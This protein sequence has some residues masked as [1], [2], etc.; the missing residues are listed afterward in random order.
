M[1]SIVIFK[2][3]RNPQDARVGADGSV[4]WRG[5]KME[6]NDDDPAAMEIASSIADGGEIIG[7]T[8]GDGD[9]SWAASRGA[10]RTVIVTDAQ[11]E[12]DSSMTGAVLASAIRQIEDVD[13]VFIGD[14]AWDYGVASALA[15]QLGWPVVAGVVSAVTE[16]GNLH[17]TRKLGGK[18]QV[19]E[20]K[21]P[22]LL[23]VSATQEARHAPSM[24]EILAGRKKP[25]VKITLSDL[26]FAVETTVNSRGTRFPETPPARIIDGTN[27]AIACEELLTALRSDGIL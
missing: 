2:W 4:D 17:V 10:A 13:A 3:S 27:P 25:V 21:G 5:I 6:V 24:K 16:Q 22:A 7:L 23:A 1:K 26:G 15:G 9:G 12:L 11:T 19:L 18:L 14:S 20:V 8:I